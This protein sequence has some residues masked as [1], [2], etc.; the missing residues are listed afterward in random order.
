MF[1]AFCCANIGLWT[2]SM[3][4]I[5]PGMNRDAWWDGEQTQEQAKAHLLEFDIMFPDKMHWLYMTTVV[6]IIAW[7]KMR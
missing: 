2:G 4:L 3:K 7:Q 6:G 5:T 1:A